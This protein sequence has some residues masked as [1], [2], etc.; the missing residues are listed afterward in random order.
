M[1]FG[2]RCV[3]ISSGFFT[4]LVEMKFSNSPDVADTGDNIGS[5]SFPSVTFLS[6]LLVYCRY[7]PFSLSPPGSDYFNLVISAFELMCIFGRVHTLCCLV[8]C[9]NWLSIFSFMAFRGD[10]GTSL[11]LSSCIFANFS[12]LPRPF[13]FFVCFIIRLSVS[14]EYILQ[15][16]YIR[17]NQI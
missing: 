9:C 13:L 3:N 10:M 4:N 2:D 6:S 11:I 17:N 5:S 15:V 14:N 8:V 12:A 16:K 1:R 7:L